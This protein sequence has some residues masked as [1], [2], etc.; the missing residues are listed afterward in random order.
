MELRPGDL[1][2]VNNHTVLH[3]RTSYID[4]LPPA[5]A[6][7]L[8]RC[9]ITFPD[10]RGRRPGAVDEG[11][12]HGWL[13]DDLQRQAAETWTPPRHPDDPAV[14]GETDDPAGM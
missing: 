8:L 6:R 11:L 7:H 12:R 4:P 3:S 5:S 1:Q 9:W 10:Y 13:T 14:S 2:I